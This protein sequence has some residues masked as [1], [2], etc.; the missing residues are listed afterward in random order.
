MGTVSKAL[1]LL[2]L[3]SRTRPQAGLSEIARLSGLNKATAFRLLGELEAHGFVERAGPAREYRLGPAVVRLGGLREA[4][5]PRRAVVRPVLDRLAGTTGETAHLS[6]IEGDRLGMCAFAYSNRHGTRVGMEDAEVLPLHATSSGLAVLAFGPPDLARRVLAGPLP[7]LTPAT[8]C[9]AGD[10]ARRIAAVR[11]AG[12]AESVGGYEADVH[13]F[14]LPVYGQAGDCTGALAVAAPVG[15]IT[16]DLAATIRRALVAAR[17]EIH[18]LW[19]AASPAAPPA[20]PAA[21]RSA[22]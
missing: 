20:D 11:A 12:I 5:L 1:D 19:G 15:R 3:F 21:E 22:S 7:R 8:V 4:I 14:A 6:Q 10:L 2:G 18:G 13:S 17:D 9:D 16:P